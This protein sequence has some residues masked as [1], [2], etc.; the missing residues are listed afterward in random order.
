MS[1]FKFPCPKCGQNILCDASNAGMQIACPACQTTLTVPPPPPPPPAAPGKLSINKAVHH[2]PA[3]TPPAGGASAP[4]QPAAWGTKP[5]PQKKKRK[6]NFGPAL[7][8][9]FALAV[10]GAIAWFAF[11]APYFKA[12][13]E[14]KKQAD[15]EAAA[16]AKAQEE[17]QRLAAEEAARPK[18]VWK[19]NLAEAVIPDAPAKGKLHGVDFKA[20]MVLFQNDFLTLRQDSGLARQFVI[21]VPLKSGE[22]LPGKSLEVYSTNTIS[23]PR[24]GLNWKSDSGQPP[25]AQTFTKGYAMKLE[26]GTAT[27]DGSIPGKI[28]LALPDTEQSFVAGT[29]E[30][31]SKKAAGQP[32]AAA[33]PGEPPRRRKRDS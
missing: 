33:A 21:S 4:Q 24:I 10:A 18:A 29:F 9:I 17:A 11:G 26:F 8:S 32:G 25:G 16:Q 31:G 30:I 23:Q 20:E 14:K 15:A 2:K 22:M 12:Q 5:P 1:E 3:A 27:P 13:A 7:G 28:Y 6:F 19:L